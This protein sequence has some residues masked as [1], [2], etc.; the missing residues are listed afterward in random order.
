VV[1]IVETQ[2]NALLARRLISL[3]EMLAV[4]LLCELA[5]VHK[6][7]GEQ[8]LTV[9]QL[10]NLEKTPLLTGDVLTPKV[11]LKLKIWHEAMEWALHSERKFSS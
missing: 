5:F 9:T 11:P 4:E 8:F 10:P 2:P 3:K 7:K 1:R 6:R